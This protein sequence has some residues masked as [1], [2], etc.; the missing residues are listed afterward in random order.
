MLEREGVHVVKEVYRSILPSQSK[1]GVY[2]IMI[3]LNRDIQ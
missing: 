3:P 2:N 1:L